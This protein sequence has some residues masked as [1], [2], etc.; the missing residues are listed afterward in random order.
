MEEPIAIIDTITIKRIFIDEYPEII[1]EL[2]SGVPGKKII[3]TEDPYVGVEVY[4]RDL[5]KEDGF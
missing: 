5:E 1:Y 4:L 2:P 3:V